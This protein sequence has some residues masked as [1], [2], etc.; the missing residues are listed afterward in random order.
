MQSK[1]RAN[2][3]IRFTN[4]TTVAKQFSLLNAANEMFHTSCIT[5]P[6]L[7]VVSTG[8]QQY[9]LCIEACSGFCAGRVC[10]LLQ[11]LCAYLPLAIW[12]KKK[13]KKKK[14]KKGRIERERES[15]IIL[16]NC[17]LFGFYTWLLPTTTRWHKYGTLKNIQYHVKRSINCPWD[18]EIKSFVTWSSGCAWKIILKHAYAMHVYTV[19]IILHYNR[20][21]VHLLQ[22]IRLQIT[23]IS[24]LT[25]SIQLVWTLRMI[26]N[27]VLLQPLLMCLVHC[28]QPPIF[29]NTDSLSLF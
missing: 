8:N 10:E 19:V 26:G 18:S 11:V 29:M 23:F 9:C 28:P 27:L 14:R 5:L 15:T 24:L 1:I 13:K 2:T 17:C 7:Q 22:K 12:K 6:P 16:W 21:R 25:T 20:Y 3:P 4:F